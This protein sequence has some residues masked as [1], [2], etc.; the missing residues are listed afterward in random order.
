MKKI[1]VFGGTFN[2][3]HNGHLSLARRFALAL[4]AEKVL[5]MPAYQP[6][7]KRTPEFASPS[8]RLAMCRL[9][10]KDGPFEVSPL[11]IERGGRSYTS[12]TLRELK[13]MEPDSELFFLTGEDMFLTI[14]RWREPETIFS[15]ATICAAPRSASGLKRLLEHETVLRKLGARTVVLDIPYLPVSSTEVREAV[16]AGKSI[17]KLVPPAV[18]EYIGRNHL[19]T[20]CGKKSERESFKLAATSFHTVTNG[21]NRLRRPVKTSGIQK[22]D[23]L[24]MN[25]EDYKAVIKPFLSEKRYYHSVCVQKAALRLAKKYG[26][27]PEKASVAGILH[28]IMKDLP[29]PEQLER[30]K[31][32]GV[33]LT[34]LELAAPKLWHAI[35]GAAYLRAEL[36]IED[37]EILGAVRFH[38][39]GRQN[40]T[41][42]EKV[43]FVA[44]FIS[45]DRDYPGV[46]KMRAAARESLEEAAAEGIVFTLCDLAGSRK[47]IH[48]DTIAAYNDMVLKNLS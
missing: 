14:E 13:R 43:L 10:A 46:E 4:G 41:L 42:L 35:L 40:M 23:G 26:A 47:P 16:R 21:A 22:R 39:T 27:D 2:P 30:M 20:E 17:E 28:D 3:I 32:Y 1:A 15:L 12:D 25:P 45:D 7:H 34:R 38:T 6:P 33:T 19:Y 48:P 8:D 37:P 5:F 31:K 11:E 24:R 9:A 36:H 18:A 29:Q 44:D